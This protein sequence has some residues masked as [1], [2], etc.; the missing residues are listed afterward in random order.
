MRSWHRK[1]TLCELGDPEGAF[2]LRELLGT[3][4]KSDPVLDAKR[5]PMTKSNLADAKALWNFN[6]LEDLKKFPES[7]NRR[8]W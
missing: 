1:S 5:G 7:P 4:V 2:G 3:M 8:K 6:D